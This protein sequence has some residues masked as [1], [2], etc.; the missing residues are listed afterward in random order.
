MAIKTS[1]GAENKLKLLFG[2]REILSSAVYQRA[3]KKWFPPKTHK[4]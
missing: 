1:I 2:A 4:T 3:R